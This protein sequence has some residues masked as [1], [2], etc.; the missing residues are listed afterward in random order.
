MTAPWPDDRWNG[1]RWA[2][3][4]AG[5][6]V[7]CALLTVTVAPAMAA[8]PAR[9]ASRWFNPK[10][11]AGNLILPLPCG[12]A[13]AFRPVAVLA[14]TGLLAD[15]P[16]TLG[17]ANATLG[18][19]QYQRQTFLAAPFKGPGASRV[20][21][22]GTYPVT[23]DQYAAVMGT[24]PPAPSPHGR[25][26]MTDVSWFAAVRF[27][28]RLSA[29]L[30]THA[31]AALPEH[32]GSAGFVRLPTEAEWEYA[33]RGG[34]AVSTTEYEARLWPM[35]R[36]IRRYLPRG[37]DGPSQ[38]GLRRPN[39]LG[40]Y[41]LLGNVWQWTLTP[42]RLN[43]VGRA[44]GQPGGLV[45]RGGGYTTAREA[46]STALREEVPPFDPATGAATKLPFIG[47]R[48]AIGA[49]AGGNLAHV[50]RLKAAF[51][52]LMRAPA[53][54]TRPTVASVAAALA[55]TT[56]DAALHTRLTQL[57][58]RLAAEQR[59]Q[60]DAADTALHAQLEAASALAYAIWRVE[61]IIRVQ[62]AML[63]DPQ[64]KLSSGTTQFAQLKQ[65]VAGN[66]ADQDS[67]LD[68]YATLLR[69]VAFGAARADIGQEMGLI[70]REF[71]ASADRRRRFLAVIE[72][73]ALTM[74][75][76]HVLVAGVL[77][78]QI[79]AVPPG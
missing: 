74:Q 40:L 33:A 46:L 1:R 48:V 54:S 62:R 69:S 61:R 9:W 34:A 32:A 15:R 75:A 26:P 35:P 8:G 37:S 10:S 20:F 7:L 21:Y 19:N 79:V 31:R 60:A 30:L 71:A 67:A 68:A 16:I 28:E 29:W 47:F 53:K 43:R 41:D 12:G 17:S 23:R 44:Q 65:A 11:A 66:R 56:A 27:T 3:A 36:G 72:Q 13:I 57:A 14:G 52:T 77:R 58:A 39:P 5:P 42:Y 76:G 59:A 63:V 45:A 4:F 51:A 6:L 24:C 70:G 50:E 55:G 22:L 64:F 78:R 38:I 25:L 73:Q 49:V 18:Y 2:G